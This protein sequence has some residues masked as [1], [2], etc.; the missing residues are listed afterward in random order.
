MAL[1]GREPERAALDALVASARQGLSAVLVL[2]GQAGIGK[3]A[4][5]DDVAASAQDMQVMRVAGVEAESDF[6]FAALHRL[7][8]P[9]LRDLR[10]FPTSQ[11]NALQVAC[12]LVDGP[13]ADRHLVSLA[14]LSLLAEVASQT[15][16][17]CCVDDAQW[18]DR[19]SADAL[20]FVARRMYADSI[21]LVFAIRGEATEFTALDGLPARTVP[22]LSPQHALD[23]L[24]AVV[25]GPLDTR[26]ANHIVTA[27]AGN[28]LALI[29]LAQELSTHQ[30]IGGTLL[31]QPLPIGS[32]LEAHYL[33]QVRTLPPG[34]ERWLLLA[35][36]EAAGD[37]GYISQAATGLGIDPGAA[38]PAETARLVTLRPDVEFR[39]PLVRSAIY[40]G[41]TT[42]ERRSAHRALATATTRPGDEDRRAWHLAAASTGPD[43]DLAAELERSAQ[44]AGS[45]GGY[46]ARATFLA[47]AAELTPNQPARARRLLAAAEAALAA[48]APLQANSLLDSIDPDL[49]DDISRGRSLMVRAA[50]LS[51]LGEPGA[52]PRVAAIC[53]AAA[54]AFGEQAPDLAR[55][56]LLRAFQYAIAAEHLIRDTT[57]HEIAEAA[58][59]HT[60]ASGA[61][62]LPDLLLTGLATL[63][64]DS[65]QAAVPYLRTA[66]AALTASETA[67]DEIL[68]HCITAVS[69]CTVL[70]DERSRDDILRRA[71]AIARRTGAL[72]V[73]DILLYCLSLSETTL[74]RLASADAYLIEAQQMRS[75]IG[76]T[77]D[78]VEIYRSPELLAWHGDDKQL[79]EKL[80]R[81]LEAS[82]ALGMGA[83]ESV[84]RI[85]L[86][87]LEIGS[88]NYTEACTIARQLIDMDVIHIHSRLLPELVESALRSGNRILA[89]TALHSLSAKA[90][91]SGTPWALGLQARSEALLAPPNHAE[92]LYQKAIHQLEQT[93]ARSDLGR[94]HLL[95]GEWLRRQKR[96]RDAREHLRAALAMFED[97]Q[98]A[99]FADRARQELAATGEYARQRSVETATDLTPQEATIAKLARTGATN[100]E[101]AAHLF[102]SAN[103]VD[104]H[105]RKIFRKLD[106]TS[107][108]QLKRA[109][110]D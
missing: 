103:T 69:A 21:G 5:L 77:A 14:T 91:A 37:A 61:S 18:L 81:S 66:I 94:A 44:R 13:A 74:G 56:T 75:A 24:H 76:A 27:T 68:L 105:L 43:E 57:T 23:L 20:A 89:E 28:P 73:L 70:W 90:T 6:P 8:L 62:S 104:Y 1:L 92:P 106:I 34:T 51:V 4:L 49:L 100:P 98:A 72:Q 96:R 52:Q 80:Q 42:T 109:L 33:K 64:V 40:N 93:M 32:H 29:D 26:I 22:G 108:R 97:M 3:T 47:R 95:Y 87:T 85:G 65:Y 110:P 83:S 55:D 11:R 67:D 45:R 19:E 36:A 79:R 86:I 48:G 63:V 7:L 41:A 84:A 35:A 46:S 39:H 88:G 17:L 59:A 101:I 54:A 78:L 2:R 38:D 71:A 60:R 99:V 107:R 58:L 10:G 25:Q 12:G 102:I 16:V 15:P 9:F 82:T 31:P 50:A 53:L 30:L